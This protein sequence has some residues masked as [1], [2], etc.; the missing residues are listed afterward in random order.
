MVR[1]DGVK[2]RGGERGRKDRRTK[3]M[4]KDTEETKGNDISR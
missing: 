1:W 2:R 4:S 3:K